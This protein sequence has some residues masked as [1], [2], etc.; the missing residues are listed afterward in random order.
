MTEMD[1]KRL[2]RWEREILRKVY[3][4]VNVENK[5]L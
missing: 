2:G 1:R 3:G 4:P 5:K